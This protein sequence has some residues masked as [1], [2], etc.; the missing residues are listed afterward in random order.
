MTILAYLYPSIYQKKSSTKANANQATCCTRRPGHCA[1]C[2]S[3]TWQANM[4]IGESNLV[5]SDAELM[6][7]TLKNSYLQHQ[8]LKIGSSMLK[9]NLIRLISTNLYKILQLPF[10]KYQRYHH[11]SKFN[12]RHWE[13]ELSSR[14]LQDVS[15]VWHWQV[16]CD[17]LH[18]QAGS[19][20]GHQVE[21]PPRY[22]SHSA[23]LHHLDFFSWPFILASKKMEQKHETKDMQNSSDHTQKVRPALI[24]LESF[25][26]EHPMVQHLDFLVLAVSCRSEV[27]WWRKL[28]AFPWLGS[29]GSLVRIFGDSRPVAF[30]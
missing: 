25:T 11:R 21:C 20:H 1:G 22:L 3:A 2:T 6:W 17:L 10:S 28:L 7:K 18:Y 15:H 24:T 12:P 14:R 13:V 29:P 30:W 26:S 5:Q 27:Q 4:S 23:S 8:H 16:S 19:H 9:I